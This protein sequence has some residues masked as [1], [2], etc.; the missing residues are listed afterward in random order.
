VVLVVIGV[1]SLLLPAQTAFVFLQ[2]AE[3]S[4]WERAPQSPLFQDGDLE[5]VFT[6]QE[7]LDARGDRDAAVH[8]EGTS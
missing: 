7:R 3:G 5:F 6:A 4:S 1:R 2:Y 8:A